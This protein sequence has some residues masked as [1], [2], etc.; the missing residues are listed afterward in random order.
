MQN[1]NDDEPDVTQQREEN[2]KRME[3]LQREERQRTKQRNKKKKKQKPKT[4]KRR[5]GLDKDDDDEPMSPEQAE[6]HRKDAER[7]DKSAAKARRR[8]EQ[9]A[10][11]HDREERAKRQRKRERNAERDKKRREQE[12][13]A[14]R[15]E[16][17]REAKD[18][19]RARKRDEQKR[20]RSEQLAEDARAG[21]SAGLHAPGEFHEMTTKSW[22][23]HM[24]YDTV[25][26]MFVPE[27]D[28]R[29]QGLLPRTLS[30]FAATRA[31][32]HGV[33][34][35]WVAD[36]HP[37]A[38]RYM[39][40]LLGPAASEYSDGGRT[41][42]HALP[43][44]VIKPAKGL[45]GGIMVSRPTRIMSE[46]VRFLDGVEDGQ[47]QLRRVPALPSLEE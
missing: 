41:M 37:Q 6:E 43:L 15:N 34:F 32:D 42:E 7:R 35:A 30:S 21:I 2:K 31:T 44:A 46:G 11:R 9:L 40:E 23:A 36:E 4:K 28:M 14:E 8:E 39:R 18:A 1:A 12:R 47:F 17:Q 5:N 38:L 13:E 19:E 24:G 10:K 33:H 29:N 3:E 45:V 22:A 26:V 25:V 16:Q 20:K 27:L